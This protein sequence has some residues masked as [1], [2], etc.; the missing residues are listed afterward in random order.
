M[1]AGLRAPRWVG[2]LDIYPRNRDVDRLRAHRQ[3]RPRAPAP[4]FLADLNQ[5]VGGEPCVLRPLHMP[6][7]R[8]EPAQIPVPITGH[9][10]NAM[11]FP[12]SSRVKPSPGT[13]SFRSSFGFLPPAMSLITVRHSRA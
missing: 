6:S 7:P 2:G 10:S 3:Y 11:R 1:G 9:P 4:G 8:R 5:R 12:I 13:H